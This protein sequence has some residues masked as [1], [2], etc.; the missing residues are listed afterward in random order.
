M[1]K[2][3]TALTAAAAIAA[4][5]A[6]EA[7]DTPKAKKPDCQTTRCH[8]R[9]TTRPFADW[10]RRLR[11]CES[12]DTNNRGYFRGYYQFTWSTWRLAGGKGDPA[13]AA[14]LE[15]SFRAVKWRKRIGNPRQTAGW[16]NCA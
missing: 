15:Q 1:M 16:P 11:W 2:F 8:M 6:A 9:V 5:Q 3:L 12:R 14:K 7:H 13:D 4:P 10:L